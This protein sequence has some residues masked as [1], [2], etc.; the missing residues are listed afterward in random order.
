MTSHYS[1]DGSKS[2]TN[3]QHSAGFSRMITR[4]A[5]P[6]TMQSILQ[7]YIAMKLIVESKDHELVVPNIKPNN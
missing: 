5:G 3:R 2:A 7:P 6:I 4:E 1:N